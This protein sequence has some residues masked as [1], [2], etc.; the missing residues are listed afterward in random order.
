[1]LFQLSSVGLLTARSAHRHGG[2]LVKGPGSQGGVER[3]I[4]TP[5][6]QSTVQ[7]R[8]QRTR[9]LT[10]SYFTAY[11]T[12]TLTCQYSKRRVQRQE[13]RE[14]PEK[15]TTKTFG[16]QTTQASEL[17]GIAPPRQKVLRAKVPEA[18]LS[19]PPSVS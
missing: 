17:L 12:D 11:L 2:E 9:V 14:L 18:A 6:T 4:D 10:R 13:R 8:E 15:K 16:Q 1:M 7:P 5:S 19:E 3:H